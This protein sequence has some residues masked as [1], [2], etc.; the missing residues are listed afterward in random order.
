MAENADATGLNSEQPR[1]QREQGALAGAVEAEQG[2]ETCRRNREVDVDKGAPGAIAMAEAVDRQR[3]HRG[4]GVS[5][6][7]IRRYRASDWC[8]HGRHGGATVMPQGNSPT[9]IVLI[10]FC[11]ATSI[12]ETSL[13]TPLVTSRYLSSGVNAMCQTRWPTR[14]YLVTV[15]LVASTTAMRLAGPSAMKAV[16]PSLVIPMPTGWIASRRRPGMLKLILPVMMRLAGSMTDTV[17]PISDDTHNSEPSGLNSAKRGRESTSTLATTWRVA[18]SMK[19]AILVVSDV[20]IR[21]LPSGL[22]AMPSGSTPT[23]T[24]PRRVRFSTSMMVTV[25][26]FSL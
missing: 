16:L 9:W 1:H 24:S 23:W 14:R 20:L 7:D 6:M 19:C 21:I 17:P 4:S 15:W 22:M 11:A 18:V 3:G 26:S 10:T 5:R 13:D 2:G 25:L 12:T 8:V